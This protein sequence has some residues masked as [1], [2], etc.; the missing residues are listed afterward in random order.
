MRQRQFDLD[1][2][3]PT[4]EARMSRCIHH[5]LVDG[6]PEAPAPLRFERQCVGLKCEMDADRL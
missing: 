6:H 2:T 3:N 1:L 4:V 5:Q